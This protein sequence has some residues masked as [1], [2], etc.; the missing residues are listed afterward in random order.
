MD[1]SIIKFSRRDINNSLSFK[2][3]IKAKNIQG[4]S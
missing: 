2:I 3:N 1:S 4:L